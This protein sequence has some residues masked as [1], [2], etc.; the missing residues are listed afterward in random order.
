MAAL[1]FAVGLQLLKCPVVGIGVATLTSVVGKALELQ[2]FGIRRD[3]GDPVRQRGLIPVSC[4]ST[5]MAFTTGDL[6]MLS[7]KLKSGAGVVEF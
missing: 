2:D 6:L 5:G 7:G 4:V 1:T 3:F